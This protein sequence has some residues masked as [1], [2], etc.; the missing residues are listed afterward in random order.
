MN[1][2]T[3]VLAALGLAVAAVSPVSA[4]ISTSISFNSTS[5][6]AGITSWP[7][8]YT[9]TTLANPSGYNVGENNYGG[10]SLFSLGQSWTATTS[11]NLTR[12]QIAISGTAPVS[13]N[14]SLYD[15]G[16]SG[17]ADITSG[18]YTPGGNVS[19]NLFAD[20]SVQTWQ[21]FTLQ[22]ATAGVLDFSLSG[23]DQV[24]IIAGHQYIFEISSTSNPNGMVWYRGSLPYAGGS[25][26][27]QRSPLN[28]AVRDMTL[29][30]TVVTVPE[31]ASAALLG[32]GGLLVVNHLRRRVKA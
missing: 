30:A 6:I 8:A 1:H 29:A 24:S 22:G 2:C 14:V 16:T 10:A 7:N 18:T 21:Q 23:A 27:R 32:M 5:G 25:A 17:W 3:K 28:G 19:A 9:D 4:A 20:T 26:F 12:L 11:G 31:P 13:F 15:G